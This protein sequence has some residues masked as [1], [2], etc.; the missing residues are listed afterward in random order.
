MYRGPVRG[1]TA[2]AP[3]RRSAWQQPEPAARA[4]L[5]TASMMTPGASVRRIGTSPAEIGV[6]ASNLQ[7]F[8]PDS[9]LFACHPAG[10][11][12]R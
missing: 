8:D 3:G 10:L 4:P 5:A 11:R 1:R 2:G 7:P 12:E 9:A 6:D